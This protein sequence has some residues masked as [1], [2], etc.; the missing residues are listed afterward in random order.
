MSKASLS[1]SSK[2]LLPT[3]A[4]AVIGMAAMIGVT[5]NAQRTFDPNTDA[6]GGKCRS[7]SHP[8]D[9]D[10][11]SRHFYS[12]AGNGT[13]SAK[14]SRDAMEITQPVALAEATTRVKYD[15]QAKGDFSTEIAVQDIKMTPNKDSGQVAF[16]FSSKDSRNVAQ[17]GVRKFENGNSAVFTYTNV[18]G[19]P[20]IEWTATKK[21]TYPITLSIERKA[22]KAIYAY[23][24]SKGKKEVLREVTSPISEAVDIRVASQ[25][26]DGFPKVTGLF[27]D[28]VLRC[29]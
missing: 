19:T 11:V 4:I 22:D 20:T 29:N 5:S 27:S 10:F 13:V 16:D 3:L 17:V 26:R 8:L 9:K 21:F 25:T 6:A 18:N 2:M 23:K 12:R 28:F 24:E 15:S 7:I 1:S 14:Q